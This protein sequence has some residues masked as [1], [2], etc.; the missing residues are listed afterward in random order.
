MTSNI[1]YLLFGALVLLVNP[2]EADIIPCIPRKFDQDSIV[3]VCNSTYCDEI[4][5]STNDDYNSYTTTLDG[6]RFD[7]ASGTME[8]SPSKPDFAEIGNETFQEIIGF[9]GAHVEL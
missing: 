4:F 9:G 7:Y 8:L 1:F 6:K 5:S 3:C 2:T